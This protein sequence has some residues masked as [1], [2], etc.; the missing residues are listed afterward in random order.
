MWIKIDQGNGIARGP[1]R[2]VSLRMHDKS[3]VWD[4]SASTYLEGLHQ[5]MSLRANELGYISKSAGVVVIVATS[6][7]M[8]LWFCLM[9]TFLKEDSS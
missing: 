1:A 6:V 9:G 8:D 7:A 4:D 2:A 5:A 3:W